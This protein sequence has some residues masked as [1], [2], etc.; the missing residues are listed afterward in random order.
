MLVT[1][2]GIVREIKRKRERVE[3][4]RVSEYEKK[5]DRKSEK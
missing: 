2:F 3:S 1:R 4:V 5:S